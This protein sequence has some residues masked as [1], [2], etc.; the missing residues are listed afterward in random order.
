M[1]L[2]DPAWRSKDFY[3]V[4]GVEASADAAAIKKAYRRLAQQYHP[5]TNQGDAAAEAKFKE[6]AEA[7]EVLGNSEKRQAYDQLRAGG[8]GPSLGFGGSLRDDLDLSDLHY[9]WLFRDDAMGSPSGRTGFGFGG[10]GRRTGF[11]TK[12][13]TRQAKVTVS[14]DQAARGDSLTLTDEAGQEI[15]VRLPQ[16]IEDGTTILVPGQGLPSANGGPAGDLQ[17]TVTVQPHPW[18]EREGA[19]LKLTLP[20]TFDELALGATVEAPTY[21]SGS[22]KLRIPAGTPN[23]RTLKVRGKGLALAEGLKGDLLVTVRV[24]VPKSLPPEAI[25]AVEAYRA[26]TEI[27]T[28]RAKYFS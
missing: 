18:F 23:G 27:H 8:L 1:A 9:D 4:L 12:G 17:L 16:G 24:E 13:R 6:L 28:P 19:D 2:A 5:D 25:A 22:V 21:P 10:S 26:A 15:A 11:P 14:F 7:Y 3:A 20:V